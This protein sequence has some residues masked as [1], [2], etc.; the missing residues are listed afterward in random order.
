MI[1]LINISS[2][3]QY[4]I[5]LS[6]VLIIPKLL[7]RF[8]IPS[9][10]SALILGCLC[11]NFLGWFKDSQL[12]LTLARLGITSLF[13]FAGM[14]INLSDLRKEII[15]LS[16][17]L[18]Q[19]LAII[20]LTATGIYLL[21]GIS[22]QIS[23]IL[24]IAIFTPS[25]GFIL[26]SLKYYDL[27]EKEIFWIKLKAIS[28]EIAAILTLFV[29]LQL[30]DLANLVKV[31]FIFIVIL[32]LL[33]HLFKFFLRFIAPYAPKSEVSFLV[34]VAFMLGIITKK[35]GTYYLV[36]AFAA[37][38]VA[39]QFNHFINS[40]HSKRIEES[41]A[42][43]YTIFVPFYFFS[44]GLIITDD[45]FTLNGLYLG[46][47]LSLIFIPLRLTSVVLSIKLFIKDFWQDRIKISISLAPNLIFGLVIVGILKEKF[48]LDSYILSGL[49]IYTL[50]TSILPAIF[51]KKMPPE[52]YDLSRG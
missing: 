30:D 23:L 22:Y 38:I 52:N 8:R 43:F 50:T 13:L 39:G 1:E 42:A 41:L 4:L 26:S 17:Y 25:A 21:T 44:A 31:Q 14:E 5:A 33:P 20:I 45:F 36:G 7:L 37:G 3:Y 12:I 16:K 51:F 47:A 9:G 24:S 40:E 11:A 49:V 34:I 29:A 46:L 18:L 48:N 6:S 2:E 35:L 32:L 27:N 15:P 10:I 28:K 19:S